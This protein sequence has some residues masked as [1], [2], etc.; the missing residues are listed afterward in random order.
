MADARR[1]V[2]DSRRQRV[3]RQALIGGMDA[4]NAAIQFIDLRQFGIIDRLVNRGVPAGLIDQVVHIA[5]QSRAIVAQFI[6][7][8]HQR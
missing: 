4:L 2:S 1:D 6:E 3:F 5:G 8:R 7:R